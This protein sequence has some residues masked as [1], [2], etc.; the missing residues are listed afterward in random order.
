LLKLH[1]KNLPPIIIW[2]P[3]I[4]NLFERAALGIPPSTTWVN[5]Y[6]QQFVSSNIPMPGHKWDYTPGTT[7]GRNLTH[8]HNIPPIRSAQHGS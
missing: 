6:I 3:P 1:V 7:H 4:E 5:D 2:I 8:K